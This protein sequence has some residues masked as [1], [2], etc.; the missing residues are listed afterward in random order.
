MIIDD[1]RFTELYVDGLQHSED[2]Q[3]LIQRYLERFTIDLSV[4]NGIIRSQGPLITV[5]Y[6]CLYF[7]FVCYHRLYREV[8]DLA[9]S[10]LQDGTGR[11]PH[12]RYKNF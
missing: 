10:K 11:R 8:I 7:M 12:Y 2:L 1:C 4:V 5:E 9:Q 3:L 6:K